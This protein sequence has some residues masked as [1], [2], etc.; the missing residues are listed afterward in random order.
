MHLTAVWIAS[1]PAEKMLT[2]ESY[3]RI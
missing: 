2:Y 1:L 3:Y